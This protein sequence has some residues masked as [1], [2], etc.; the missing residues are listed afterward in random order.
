MA[1]AKKKVVAKRSPP[2]KKETQ[3]QKVRRGETLFKRITK[4]RTEER[5]RQRRGEQVQ[6][7]KTIASKRRLIGERSKAKRSE[8]FERRT[9][10]IASTRV[11]SEERRATRE[12]EIG[13][14][15]RLREAKVSAKSQETAESERAQISVAQARSEASRARINQRYANQQAVEEARMQRRLR[16]RELQS[17]RKTRSTS[18]GVVSRTAGQPIQEAGTSVWGVLFRIGAAIVGLSLL[19]LLV[20]HAD[21]TSST[22]GTFGSYLV[23][24]TSSK[25]IFV[26]TDTTTSSSAGAK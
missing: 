14:R 1:T 26:P 3:A 2:K 13:Q 6:T 24:V 19:L 20:S 10:R 8:I 15:I 25:P 4:F 11:A 7:R 16:F 17:T 22:V 18:P 23:G 12:H 21:Q 5:L 9:A